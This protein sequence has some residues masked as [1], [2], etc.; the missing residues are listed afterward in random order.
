MLFRSRRETPVDPQAVRMTMLS[1]A[2][3]YI[4]VSETETFVASDGVSFL[5]IADGLEVDPAAGMHAGAVPDV[6]RQAYVF[7]DRMIRQK[8]PAAIEQW[9]GLMCALLLATPDRLTLRT[10]PMNASAGS[11][12]MRAVSK[13]M[14]SHRPEGSFTSMTLYLYKGADIAAP[15]VPVAF[16]IN[17]DRRFE[18]VRSIFPELIFPAAEI[19]SP[20]DCNLPW[21]KALLEEDANSDQDT[22][23][24]RTRRHYVFQNPIPSLQQPMYLAEA[25]ALAGALSRFRQQCTNPDLIDLLGSYI[26]Q[27]SAREHNI[28]VPVR[29]AENVIPGL[30]QNV[31]RDPVVEKM[32]A[33]LTDTLCLIQ[34]ESENTPSLQN[35]RFLTISRR[36]KGERTYFSEAVLPL[37]TQFADYLLSL[38]PDARASLLA[39]LDSMTLEETELGGVFNYTLRWTQGVTTVTKQYGPG[40]YTREDK[41]STRTFPTLAIWPG[42]RFEETNPQF[43]WM[44]YYVFSKKRA[45]DNTQ[46]NAYP[47]ETSGGNEMTNRRDG[48][49]FRTS[50]FPDVLTVTQNER[51]CGLLLP[52]PRPFRA[53]GTGTRIIGVDFGTSNTIAYWKKPA[54]MKPLPL[55]LTSYLLPITGG[56]HESDYCLS[57]FSGVDFR[58]DLFISMLRVEA[59]EGPLNATR[60]VLGSSIPF[61]T[62]FDIDGELRNEMKFDLKWHNITDRAAR[63]YT[64]AFLSQLVQMYS[65]AAKME[66]ATLLLWRFSWPRAMTTNEYETFK[67]TIEQI[68]NDYATLPH[69]ITFFSEADAVGDYITSGAIAASIT[70]NGWRAIQPEF[71]FASIDI[72]G[73]SVDIS[74]WQNNDLCAEASLRDVAAN[75]VLCRSIVHD[76]VELPPRTELLAEIFNNVSLGDETKKFGAQMKS[77]LTANKTQFVNKWTLNIEQIADAIR[78]NFTSVDSL[79]HLRCYERM[80]EIYL[81]AVVHFT[82]VLTRQAIA[83]GKMKGNLGQNFTLLFSGNGSQM[84][85]F[86]HAGEAQNFRG[87]PLYQRLCVMFARGLGEK[88]FPQIIV[89]FMPKHE[90]AF[91]MTNRPLSEKEQDAQ[92]M[93]DVNERNQ[94]NN[95]ELLDAMFNGKP[96]EAKADRRL[97]WTNEGDFAQRK[98]RLKALLAEFW[99]AFRDTYAASFD[100]VIA[101]V[102]GIRAATP[103]AVFAEVIRYTNDIIGMLEAS[104]AEAFRSDL[105]MMFSFVLQTFILQSRG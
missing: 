47:A 11:L 32:S 54:D 68:V 1:S 66:G 101:D 75:T 19:A 100:R 20:L 26:G 8:D 28:A 90:V 102:F 38:A 48:R 70:N 16:A 49:V 64:E 80:I 78:R 71:G 94:G 50:R 34:R 14:L 51:L 63:T 52:K 104:N 89:P 53:N 42:V 86:L 13:S 27:I 5:N 58:K 72:G 81:A 46:I 73:G 59:T 7:Q 60:A 65:F 83:E 98:E 21:Y 76:S 2:I 103:D 31:D 69:I 18:N 62:N 95:M 79:D 85:R 41:L 45:E 43:A 105:I 93:W 84:I 29:L 22:P 30:L 87:S 12:F 17:Y 88:F 10:I 40:Q 99:A 25:N 23:E 67:G 56:D 39:S 82:A 37:N 91:G 9:L 33:Y 36:G 97:G 44:Q 57:F 77:L 61:T 4:N 3:P 74:L 35:T 6:L 92:N 55:N 15:L 24:R 96:M